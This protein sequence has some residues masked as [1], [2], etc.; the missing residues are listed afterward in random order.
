M[1]KKILSTMGIGC[2]K[3]D[4]FILTREVTAGEELKGEVHIFGGSVPQT[5]ENISLELNVLSYTDDPCTEFPER[6][7]VVEAIEIKEKFMINEKEE[8]VIPFE[9]KV[10]NSFPMTCGNTEY[11]LSTKIGIE[12][13]MDGEDVDSVIV[14][15]PTIEEKL[16]EYTAN[17]FKHGEGSGKVK[18]NLGA[19]DGL[20]QLFKLY[21]NNSKVVLCFDGEKMEVIEKNDGAFETN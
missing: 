21:K 10:K 9:I 18:R 5:I 13:S 6:K 15:N 19:T 12:Y 2:A 4:T 14:K 7:E 3:V 16:K 17:G 8:K 20:T 1:I 11:T